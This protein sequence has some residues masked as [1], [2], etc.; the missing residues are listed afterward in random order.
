M[1][2]TVRAKEALKVKK[3][4]HIF[5]ILIKTIVIISTSKTL[6]NERKLQN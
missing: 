4:M 6:L 2:K 3:N 5:Q 1:A